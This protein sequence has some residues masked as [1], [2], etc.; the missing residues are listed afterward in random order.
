MYKYTF[1][2][3]RNSECEVYLHFSDT[4]LPIG[5]YRLKPDE[6][7]EVKFYGGKR[8]ND[9]SDN[10][11]ILPETTIDNNLYRRV[12]MI[13]DD[14]NY[15][16]FY[17]DCHR[18]KN[19]YHINHTLD[20]MY[21]DCQV[22]KAEL[23]VAEIKGRHMFEFNILADTLDSFS[24]RVITQWERNSSSSKLPIRSLEEITRL[25]DGELTSK[26]RIE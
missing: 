25:Y 22:T 21:P 10:Q 5:R 17:L 12:K 20:E 16:I 1:F 7:L 13:H 11:V 26:L 23:I 2:D 9:V 3:M 24:A 4:A 14:G 18:K 6:W 19:M 8:K 15:Y